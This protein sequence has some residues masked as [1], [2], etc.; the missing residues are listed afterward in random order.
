VRNPPNRLRLAVVLSTLTAGC[1]AKAIADPSPR[2]V[3]DLPNAPLIGVAWYPEQWPEQRW[4]ADLTLMQQAG[5]NV[6]RVGEFSWSRMK[7]REGVYD[8][9]WLERVV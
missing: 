9:D 6:I 3:L 5:L 8:L 1:C 7:A 4:N 2:G